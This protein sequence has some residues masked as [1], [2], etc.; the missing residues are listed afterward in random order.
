[1]KPFT[2]IGHRGACAHE[3]ENTLRSIRRALADGA[4][5]IEIDVRFV[6]GEILVFHDD[7]L[8]RTTDGSG[9][10]YA[11]TFPQLRALNAGQGEQIPTLAEVLALTGAR[12]TLNIEF[13]DAASVSPVCALIESHPREDV[14]LSAFVWENLR[15]A[16]RLSPTVPIGVLTE[17]AGGAAL[18]VADTLRAASLHPS[19]KVLTPHYVAEAR[20]RNLPVLPYT[21]R[22]EAELEKVRASGADGCFADDPAWVRARFAGR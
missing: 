21:V 9:P 11:L 7:T 15:E 14:L 5:M 16:R 20:A 10:V 2:I 3:P 17:E 1:M 4:D 18:A 13:K 6:D 12:V 8:E 19:L 22:T